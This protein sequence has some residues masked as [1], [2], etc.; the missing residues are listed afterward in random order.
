M[1]KTLELG[2]NCP[3][4]VRYMFCDT[5]PTV[6]TRNLNFSTFWPTNLYTQNFLGLAYCIQCTAKIV[7]HAEKETFSF[8]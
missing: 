5:Q 1:L 6:Q 2:S 4:T 7:L 3:T 8:L